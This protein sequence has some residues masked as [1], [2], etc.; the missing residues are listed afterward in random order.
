MINEQLN[1]DQLLTLLKNTRI[2]QSSDIAVEILAFFLLIRACEIKFKDNNGLE[3]YSK[4]NDAY[5]VHC[6]NLIDQL[7]H[8]FQYNKSINQEFI[9]KIIVHLP[10]SLMN[11]SGHPVFNDIK[12]F[13]SSISTESD[14]RLMSVQF[15]SLIEKMV[16]ESPMT[17]YMYTSKALKRMMVQVLSPQHGELIYDPACGTGGFLI[18]AENYVRNNS[19][20]N[21]VRLIGKEINHLPF[22]FSLVNFI[23]N[24][25]DAFQIECVDTI[26]QDS[27]KYDNEKYD[28]ILTNPPFGKQNQLFKNDGYLNHKNKYEYLEYQFLDHVINSLKSNGKAG[29]ILPERFLY[30]KSNSGLFLRKN[31]FEDYC[32]DCIVKIPPGSMPNNAVKVIILFFRNTKPTGTTWV[33]QLNQVERF[34]RKKS[35]SFNMFDDFFNKYS[36]L[37]ES[38][39]SWSVSLD[40]DDLEYQLLQNP[41]SR[42]DYTDFQT[43]DSIFKKMQGYKLKLSKSLDYVALQLDEIRDKIFQINNTCKFSSCILGDLVK[44]L[45]SKPL[46][47]DRFSESGAYKVYGG[48]GVIGYF[49]KFLHSG[50]FIVI[51]R[52]GAHCGNVRYVEGKIWVTNNAL[53]AICNDTTHVYLPY[54]A[55]VLAQI[56]L[57]SI[58]TG[59]AQP[60]ITVSQIKKIDLPLP[61]LEI[62]KVLFQMLDQFDNELLK[63]S[64]LIESILTEKPLLKASLHRHL[65]RI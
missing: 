1:L 55:K 47:K 25:S 56:N 28:V 49:D 10:Y 46:S 29:I 3:L 24:N 35:I 4:N 60:H 8:H 21:Y 50:E 19:V 63:Q 27:N 48:N 6:Y 42:K 40:T 36:D 62:Q 20:R 22:L 65:M 18:E 26:L 2:V 43:P 39:N 33:Y 64:Q 15:N 44:I 51:G 32:V 52:V 12:E 30:D 11:T 38:E 58:A 41:S 14:V 23:L 53:A 59:T 9:N 17:G 5:R 13:F 7:N 61:P 16:Y 54:L 45:P 57:R 37:Q 31:L 34:S